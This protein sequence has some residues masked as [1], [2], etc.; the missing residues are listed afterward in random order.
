M[1]ENIIFI[2]SFY[3]WGCYLFFRPFWW[4][5]ISFGLVL[6]IIFLAFW[7]CYQ[8][9]SGEFPAVLSYS[10]FIVSTIRLTGCI[11]RDPWRRACGLR[12]SSSWSNLDCMYA[13]FCSFYHVIKALLSLLGPKVLWT[14]Y[15]EALGS[16]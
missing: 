13:A 12:K 1:I 2:F 7:A 11:R 4:W 14:S 10:C 16:F 3:L 5:F 8:R 6:T 9:I 15:G